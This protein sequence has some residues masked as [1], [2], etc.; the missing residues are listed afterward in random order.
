[1]FSFASGYAPD[2]ED[3]YLD[4]MFIKHSTAVIS[5]VSTAVG[6]LE[7]GEMDILIETLRD[8]GA[9]HAAASLDLD[10]THYDLVGKALLYTLSKAL[11]EA[12]TPEAEEAWLSVYRVITEEMMQGA[13]AKEDVLSK[14]ESA[15]RAAE[16]LVN[17]GFELTV[18]KALRDPALAEANSKIARE[19]VQVFEQAER[20][21]KKET[22]EIVA[23]QKQE[24]DL[25]ASKL[26]LSVEDDKEKIL[27]R[28]HSQNPL[29]WAI[30]A[31]TV[32]LAFC[33]GAYSHVWLPTTHYS[34][35]LV[36]HIS[37]NNSQT[38]SLF[39][40]ATSDT[41]SADIVQTAKKREDLKLT[42]HENDGITLI[43]SATSDMISM[44]RNQAAS[45]GKVRKS[46][47]RNPVV[48]IL[49]K[50]REKLPKRKK[51]KKKKT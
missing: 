39:N 16:A 40:D 27:A 6:L 21:E 51:K 50:I 23:E 19:K 15:M 29:I 20:Y 1:M 24:R 37:P 38:I 47:R 8:L 32:I 36:I 10:E 31:V 9:R 2:S 33:L 48:S 7:A 41:F 26:K 25:E 5:S 4:P 13:K 22:N 11:G 30:W 17:R 46:K 42:S 14:D 45:D 43:N 49:R 18:E 3:L 44:D 28:Q 35:E 12:F 34:N